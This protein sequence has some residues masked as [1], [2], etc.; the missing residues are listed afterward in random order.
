MAILI[1]SGTPESQKNFWAT[2]HG[3]F[4]DAQKLYGRPFQT[5]VA[6]EPLTAKCKRFF[7]GVEWLDA[8]LSG[9]GVEQKKRELAIS[10]ERGFRLIG[11]DAMICDWGNDF[12]CN[13]PFDLKVD[14]IKRARQMQAIGNGGMMLLP[15]EPLTDWWQENLSEGCVIYE[16]DGRYQFYDRDGETKKTGANFGS[17][18]VAFPSIKI[19]ESPRI[20]FERGVGGH[21]EF[22]IMKRRKNNRRAEKNI[23]PAVDIAMA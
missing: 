11:F 18:F 8:L 12:Y 22:D 17:A 15:Y 16:P 6:A 10:V 7:I 20:R 9:K 23:A 21:S 2:T 4:L 13:P 1:D 3:A 14:F 5:D 19:G